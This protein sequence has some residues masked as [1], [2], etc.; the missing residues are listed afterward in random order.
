MKP[1]S[2]MASMISV[3]LLKSEALVPALAAM[4]GSAD[5]VD[6]ANALLQA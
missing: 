4:Y 5:G 3:T 2:G 1:T 6:A